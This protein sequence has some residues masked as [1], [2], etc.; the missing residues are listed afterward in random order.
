MSEAPLTLTW[1]AV[2]WKFP[3]MMLKVFCALVGGKHRH[4]GGVDPHI[5]A[6]A[7]IDAGRI[8]AGNKAGAGGH[9]IVETQ[10]RAGDRRDREELVAG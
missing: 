5:A 3:A 10:G 9:H 6:A 4:P 2:T 1:A 8:G 7:R